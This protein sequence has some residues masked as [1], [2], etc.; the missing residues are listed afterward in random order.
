[1]LSKFLQLLAGTDLM[2]TSPIQV[3]FI[4][5]K[6]NCLKFNKSNSTIEMTDTFCS[7]QELNTEIYRQLRRSHFL[8]N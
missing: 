4:S 6:K 1:M 8:E 2:N 3:I 5:Y 7:Q